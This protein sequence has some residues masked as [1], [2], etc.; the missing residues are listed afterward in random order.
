MDSAR[1]LR[2]S[3]RRWESGGWSRC[4]RDSAADQVDPSE[5]E[6]ALA[7][8]GTDMWSPMLATHSGARGA[9]P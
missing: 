8:K 9:R 4:G 2:R 6:I 7:V 1:V 5:S 3:E